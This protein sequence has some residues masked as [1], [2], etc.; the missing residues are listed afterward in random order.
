MKL[1][2]HTHTQICMYANIQQALRAVLEA[3]AFPGPSLVIA[4]SPCIEH[5][6]EGTDWVAQAKRAVDS[7]YWPLYRYNPLLRDQGKNPFAL[8]APLKPKI[9]IGDFIEHENRFQRLVRENKARSQVLHKQLQEHTTER[10]QKLIE[11]AKP[12]PAPA[13]SAPATAPAATEKKPEEKKP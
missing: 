12:W 8:D 11:M 4:Y 6:I 13:A 7:G 5:G 2:T 1:D 3:E 10:L 9:T